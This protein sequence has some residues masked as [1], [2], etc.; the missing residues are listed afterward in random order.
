MSHNS[1]SLTFR[2]LLLSTLYAIIWA[3][4]T[5]AM[6]FVFNEAYHIIPDKMLRKPQQN[7][8]EHHSTD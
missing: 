1:C 6:A 3:S 2:V 4:L 5:L 7:Q 8:L